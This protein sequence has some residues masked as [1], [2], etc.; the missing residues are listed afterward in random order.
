MKYL[1]SNNDSDFK[2]YIKPSLEDTPL[3]FYF[4]K[5][6]YNGKVFLLFRQYGI[7]SICTRLVWKLQASNYLISILFVH[8]CPCGEILPGQSSRTPTLL[9]WVN[10]WP[11]KQRSWVHILWHVTKAVLVIQDFPHSI[12]LYKG[13]GEIIGSGRRG[14]GSVLD[15]KIVVDNNPQPLKGYV[16]TD[17][18]L[19]RGWNKGGPPLC[20]WPSTTI[21]LLLLKFSVFLPI[22][23]VGFAKIHDNS[24]IVVPSGVTFPISIGCKNLWMGDDQ[25]NSFNYC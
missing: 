24:Q 3:S 14:L 16:T 23:L 8:I 9:C 18:V 1:Q 6:F 2:C 20:S 25:N 21:T 22:F 4:V 5:R 19:P 12:Q 15:T 10:V 13:V 17:R 11:R 7:T